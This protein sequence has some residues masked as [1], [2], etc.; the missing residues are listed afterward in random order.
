MLK[1]VLSFLCVALILV[2]GLTL[3]PKDV[4][5]GAASYFDE[6]ILF[7]SGQDG[8]TLYR[9]PGVVITSNGTIIAYCEAREGRNDLDPLDVIL[10]RSTDGGDT[11]Q[12]RVKIA[13]GVST[14]DTM[15]NPIMVAEKNNGNVH[16]FYCKNYNEVYYRKS[17]DHGVTWSAPINMTSLFN[18]YKAEYN[19][20]TIGTGPGHGIQLENGRLL[21]PFWFSDSTEISSVSTIYSDDSGMTWNR[22]EVIMNTPTTGGIGEPVVVQLYDDSVMMNLRNASTEKLRAKT[23][24]SNGISTWSI[25]ALEDELTD[26]ACFGSIQRLTDKSGYHNNRI[27]FSN[28]NNPTSRSNLT[29]KMSMDEGESWTYSKTICTDRSAYSD[30][31]VS[32]D[33]NTIFC[34]Y[35]KGLGTE[36]YKYLA[37]ARFNLEWLT[38]GEQSLDPISGPAPTIPVAPSPNIDEHWNSLSAWTTGGGGT[39]VIQ[40]QGQLHI[41]DNTGTGVHVDM[42]NISI[43][44]S[45]TLEFKAKINNFTSGDINTSPYPT[46]L[47]TKVRDGVYMLKLD[48][49]TNGIYATTNFNT[50]SQV[51]AITIDTNWHE[52]KVAVKHGI[53]EVF[54]DGV[55]QCKFAMASSTAGDHMQHTALGT[56]ADSVDAQVEYTR[57]Y[58]GEPKSAPVGIWNLNETSGTV[59]SD[60]SG[61]LNSGAVNGAV[62]A[63]GYKSNG[64]GFDGVNDFVDVGNK[65]NLQFGIGDFT[66]SAWVKTDTIS[67]DRFIFWYGDVGNDKPQWWVKLVSGNISFA[68]DGISNPGSNSVVTNNAPVSVGQWTHVTVIRKNQE[69]KI[70]IN[71]TENNTGIS[72]NI[73]D[74]TS[75]SNSLTIGKD[76]NGTTR[77][78]DGMIDEVRLYDRA[79][80]NAEVQAVYNQ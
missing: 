34:L 58:T 72:S 40:P 6:Q 26:P 56:S 22:G 43:P 44:Q 54:M 77:Y 7:T 55:S 39:R 12:T 30:L 17:T 25:P 52:W 59:A 9:I 63:T 73:P 13:D 29:V 65:S 19:W 80:S 24:S 23:I 38:N 21:I 50:W 3:S 48:F 4:V 33:K 75:T 66:A 15:N 8:Y 51:K 79:L 36:T 60:S 18:Q 14:G 37:L 76:K 42:N 10:K 61:N 31:N 57:L 47:G 11:W 71:G 45:Y 67:S 1:K 16:F 41:A 5:K 49:R 64:L 32:A 69:I 70:F 35:E 78:W 53:A 46:T 27:L 20:L 74:V 28:I 2:S 62:W 68:I